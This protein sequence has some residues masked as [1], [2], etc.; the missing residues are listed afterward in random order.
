MSQRGVNQKP[1][2]HCAAAGLSGAPPERRSH[3]SGLG[4]QRRHQQAGGDSELPR[5]P[6][7]L[8]PPPPARP[9]RP[10]PRP[11]LAGHGAKRPSAGGTGRDADQ[12]R[13]GT[14]PAATPVSLGQPPGHGGSRAAAA[15]KAPRAQAPPP[16]AGRAPALRTPTATANPCQGPHRRWPMKALRTGRRRC[17]PAPPPPPPPRPPAARSARATRA[18]GG[19]QPSLRGSRPYRHTA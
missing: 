14:A 17:F 18:G 9:Q 7:P 10:P 15:R 8:T 11:P 13:R 6:P 4:A 19:R 2:C 3:P 5:E 1:F 12:H 16:L